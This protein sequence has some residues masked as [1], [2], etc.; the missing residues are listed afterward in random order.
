MAEDQFELI[1][2]PS[3]PLICKRMAH[4]EAKARQFTLPTRATQRPNFPQTTAASEG[5]SFGFICITAEIL[6]VTELAASNKVFSF[7][8][9]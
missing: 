9:A 1:P 6:L 8:C 4:R 2:P 5:T 7:R 3:P